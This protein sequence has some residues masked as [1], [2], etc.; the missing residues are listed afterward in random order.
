VIEWAAG[1]QRAAL[2]ASPVA[3][4]SAANPRQPPV[5]FS[6]SGLAG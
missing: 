5:S 3:L 6:M 1:D 2:L 4:A